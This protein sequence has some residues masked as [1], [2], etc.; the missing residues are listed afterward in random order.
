MKLKDIRGI[1]SDSI[2][3]ITE[4]GSPGMTDS[5]NKLKEIASTV[6]EIT[7]SLEDPEMVKNIEN[8]RSTSEAVQDVRDRTKGILAQLN[9]AGIIAETKKMASSVKSQRES[10]KSNQDLNEMIV[11]LKETVRSVRTLVA[12]LRTS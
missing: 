3:L 9:E 12:E 5:L 10:F 2:K 8:V 4:F 6:Q 11:S 1:S 7:A